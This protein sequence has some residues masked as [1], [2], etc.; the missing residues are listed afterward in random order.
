MTL[1]ALESTSPRNHHDSI[2]FQNTTHLNQQSL[3]SFSDKI[4]AVYIAYVGISF[5][6]IVV[7]QS[8][9]TIAVIYRTP[10][11]HTNQYIFLGSLALVDLMFSVTFGGN[12][13]FHVSRIKPRQI[14]NNLADT[15]FFVTTYSSLMLGSIHM[16]II[17]AE[18]YLRIADP[19]LYIRCMSKQRIFKI[20]L[21]AWVAA[22]VNAIIP[23]IFYRHDKYHTHCINTHP[24]LAYF[25][26]NALIVL[27]TI[28]IALI[29]YSKIAHLAIKHNKTANAR[30][31]QTVCEN[32]ETI[33][34]SY[35]TTLIKSIKF[36]VIVC[37]IYFAC[38][39]PPLALTIVG[40]SYTTPNAIAAFISYSFSI[41]S[42][43]NFYVSCKMN[44]SFCQALKKMFRDIK[45]HCYRHE[46]D[47]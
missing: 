5:C 45:M 9:V 19:F 35:W 11:L 34:R 3:C 22:L 20:L 28:I 16:G 43:L 29:C 25:S 27:I 23:I 14:N 18:R 8:I 31:L 39:V 38:A 4:E 47:I 21:C 6:C 41:H 17:A 15:I 2:R 32:G 24:P 7:C 40:F 10:V 30:R 42:V 1:L 12:V 13:C 46:N 37:G 44:K 36:C 33:C 26:V